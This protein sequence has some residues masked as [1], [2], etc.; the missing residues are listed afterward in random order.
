MNFDVDKALRIE[1]IIYLICLYKI[2][3]DILFNS[4]ISS[5]Y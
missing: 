4:F 5:L 1:K 2:L 3:F